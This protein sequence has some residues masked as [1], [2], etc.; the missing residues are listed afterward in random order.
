MKIFKIN[1]ASKELFRKASSTDVEKGAIG[2]YQEFPGKVDGFCG[3]K[4]SSSMAAA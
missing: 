2:S 4:A 1:S 3:V